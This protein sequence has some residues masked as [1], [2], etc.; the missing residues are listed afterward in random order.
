MIKGS[1]K[2]DITIVNIFT[3]NTEKPKY[4]NQ[5]LTEIKPEINSNTAVIVEDHNTIL[6][7]MDRSSIQ[8]I[9]K[10]ILALNNKWY[11]MNFTYI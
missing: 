9:N 2:K 8:K 10:E 5:M 3:L 1:F 6:T 11:Q 7:S 4:I